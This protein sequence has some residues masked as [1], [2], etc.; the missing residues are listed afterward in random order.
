MGSDKDPYIDEGGEALMDSYGT[1]SDRQTSHYTGNQFDIESGDEWRI[2]PSPTP[3]PVENKLRNPRKRLVK[4]S[5]AESLS[6][7]SGNPAG[8]AFGGDELDDWKE[9]EPLK[10]RRSSSGKKGKELCV[11]KKRKV[12][13]KESQFGAKASSSGSKGYGVG[14]ADHES[15]P[16][17][18][19]FWNN[20]AGHD[21]EAEEDNET[22]EFLKI[23]EK[24]VQIETS[25]VELAMIVENLMAEFEV[26][27]EE[28]VE[29]NRQ[30]KPAI[31]K[32]KMLPLLQEALSK[33][34]LQLEF[35][36]HGILTLLRNWLEPL[37]DGSLP[38]MNIRTAI[39][40]LLSD[41]PVDLEQYDQREQLKKSGLGKSRSIFN[42][43]TRYEDRRSYEDERNPH[44]RTAPKRHANKSPEKK[45][46]DDD[47]DEFSQRKK[48]CQTSLRE[49]AS[50]PEP[51]PLDFVVR[52][53]SNVNWEE[54]RA[55]AINAAM[56]A[57]KDKM[58][59]KGRRP[60]APPVAQKKRPLF[61]VQSSAY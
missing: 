12:L 16:E 55:R 59:R 40:Q 44:R 54:V 7:R 1:H 53:P 24:M 43:S 19:E 29:L 41:F 51:L 23:G 14:S 18:H 61:K 32:L 45:S 21:L 35:L 31:N 2:E 60:F 56:R 33:K 4:K 34:K 6:E 25:P 11:K 20:V 5:A 47:I 15:D 9:E 27:V 58:H 42:K 30:N 10:K 37:P 57:K 46:I 38:N 8:Q 13:P 50:L 22:N 36:D 52:P 17:L 48:I 49:R 39:L 3:A 26:T 28:D